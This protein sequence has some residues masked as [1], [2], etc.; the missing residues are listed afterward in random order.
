[1]NFKYLIGVFSLFFCGLLFAQQ[2]KKSPYTVE[3]TYQ[4]YL[5]KYP[6]I[7]IPNSVDKSDLRIEKNLVYN[8]N[9]SDLQLDLYRPKTRERLP[10][11]VMIHGGGWISG[12]RE[13]FN[14]LAAQLAKK[15]FVVAN[16]SYSLSDQRK[17]PEAI[18]D[19]NYALGYLRNNAKAYGIHKGQ[20]AVLGGSAGAQIATLVGVT[21]KTGKF[22]IKGI[23]HSV[24]AIVNIDGITSFIHPE[25]ASEGSYASYWLG[26]DR[27]EN[28]KAWKQA[29]AL[30]YL[31]KKSPPIL[32]LNSSF[33]RFHAGRDDMIQYYDSKG[34]TYSVHSFEN[35]PHSFWLLEPW[36]SPT[37][38]RITQ[39]LNKQFK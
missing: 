10:A 31:H 23:D 11:I 9:R 13:N 15:G 19:V 37:I 24:Q 7:Q 3:S 28:F 36:F 22:E 32:F 34:I 30:E 38:D 33:D 26:G 4:K 27:V 16:M 5:K 39:F 1:M 35:S 2:V 6:Y 25:A 18:Y 20:I 21:A 29:S 17:F 12:S 8:V 14:E